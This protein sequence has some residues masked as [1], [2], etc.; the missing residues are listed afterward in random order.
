MEYKTCSSSLNFITREVS[1]I[2]FLQKWK[3]L[4]LLLHHSEYVVKFRESRAIVTLYLRG[5][6]MFSCGY[7][8]G[9]KYQLLVFF[10]SKFFSHGY[11]LGQFFFLEGV[12]WVQ[13]L[14][15]W[16]FREFS[17]RG[18]FVGLNLFLEDT[19]GIYERNMNN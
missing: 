15:S 14:F 9:S 4:P 5:P 16:V 13:N 8:L 7:L 11:F 17:S 19:S 18:Y 6:Q 12:S 1:L 10:G 3:R 2:L